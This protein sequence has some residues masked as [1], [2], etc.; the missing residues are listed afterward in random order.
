MAEEGNRLSAWDYVIMVL[1]LV[2]SACIGIYYRFTGGRQ[3]TVKEYLLA[4]RNMPIFPVAVSL[5]ASFM[6]AVTLLGVSS[7]N[8]VYGIQFVVI[9]VAYVLCT[10]I[11]AYIYLPIFYNL[12]VTSAY[13]YLDRRFGKVA[14]IA[15]SLSYSVQMLLYQGIVLYA[16][17]LALE[18]LTGLTKVAA[19][20]SVGLV[21]TFYST[22]GGM[23]AVLITDVFQS[24]LMYAA[25]FSII[26]YGAIDTGGLDEI[27][28][29]ANEGG[30]IDILNFSPD[31]TIRHTW[32]TLV[33]GGSVTFLSL[34]GVNQTQVQRYMTMSSLK[35]A[36][37]SLWLQL[38]VLSLMSLSTSFSGLAIYARYYKCDPVASG[39]I[40]INDQLMPYFVVDTMG[41]LS[42]LTGL[43]IAGLFSAALSTVSATI[44]S[45]AA[46]TIEDYYKPLYKKIYK[47]DV[48]ESKVSLYTKFIA[49]CYGFV[50]VATAFVAQN[51]G[52]LFSLGMFTTRANQKGCVLAL[53]ITMGLSLWM[54]FGQPRPSS[55]TLPISI[56]GCTSLNSTKQSNFVTTTN[57]DEGDYLWLYSVSYMYNGLFDLLHEHKVNQK[58]NQTKFL[59]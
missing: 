56:E 6:S 25:V 49:L 31:P 51:L 15:A 53:A 57:T 13:E 44:N 10:P 9:N 29:I 35:S 19:I 21:C 23:K 7:E 34:Y 27:W 2:I 47:Q 42:G 24:F 58:I 12:Q 59:T 37:K 17:A 39:A 41:H 54:A 4:D 18:A 45:L 22:L 43:F 33:I 55:P 36:Q 32:F 38:P 1:V 3:K 14:R 8:Y 52:G 40:D 11:V 46:V 48:A 28:R 20:L 50:C 30:R 26:I 16:P 5:M